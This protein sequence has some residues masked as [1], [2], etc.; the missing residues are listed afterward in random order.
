MSYATVDGRRVL[1]RDD[2]C[3]VCRKNRV[4]PEAMPV[5]PFPAVCDPCQ[6]ANVSTPGKLSE[7][8]WEPEPVAEPVRKRWEGP[9]MPPAKIVAKLEAAGLSATEPP[10]EPE[11]E[12]LPPEP[13]QLEAVAHELLVPLEEF[14]TVEHL[15]EEIEAAAATLDSLSGKARNTRRWRD[16]FN[17]HGLLGEAVYSVVTGLPWSATKKADE[18][19]MTF[20]RTGRMSDG[21]IDFPPDVDVKASDHPNLVYPELK[22]RDKPPAARF[23]AQVQVSVERRGGAYLGWATREELLAVAPEYLK[24][25]ATSRSHRI[26]K[27]GLRPGLPA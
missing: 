9:F 19:V 23:F 5:L 18:M 22:P 12:P 2:L 20:A 26:F 25:G 6:R 10:A 7:M 11:P 24:P 3:T 13:V 16:D 17:R 27:S 1:R 4:P 14:V 21:G 8:T 15:W